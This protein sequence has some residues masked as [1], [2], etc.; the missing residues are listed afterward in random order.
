MYSVLIQ[1][2]QN[3]KNTPDA[4]GRGFI[5]RVPSNISKAYVSYV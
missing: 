4:L 1:S 5:R 2:M 3:R